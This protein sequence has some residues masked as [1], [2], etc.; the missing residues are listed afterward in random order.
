MEKKVFIS[1]SKKDKPVADLICRTLENENI[2]CWIAPRDIPYGNDW[3]GEIT[4]AIEQSSLFVFIL[5]EH[6]NASRQCPKEISIADNVGVPIIC[7]KTD[8]V[9]M[10]PGFKYHLSMQQMV[11]V[12]AAKINEEMTAIASAVKVKLNLGETIEIKSPTSAPK[13]NGEKYNIDKQLDEKFEEL[14]GHDRVETEAESTEASMSVK[15]KLADIAVKNFM[16]HFEDEA[17]KI[18]Q[19]KDRTE[20]ATI[21]LRKRVLNPLDSMGRYLNGKHFSIPNTD[22]I[23]TLVFQIKED[24]VDYESRSKYYDC[25]LLESIRE[26]ALGCTTYFVDDLSVEGASLIFIHFFE[27]GDKLYL[28]TGVLYNDVV[29]ICKKPSIM[30]FQKLCVSSNNI[31]LSNVGYNAES[32]SISDFTGMQGSGET[33]WHDADIRTAPIVVIDPETAELV[34]R[35]VYYDAASNSMKARMKLTNNKS[36]FAFQIRNCDTDSPYVSLTDLEQGI[37]YRKGL[38]GFPK[39]FMKAVEFLEKDGTS[40]ALYQMAL[41]FGEAGEYNDEG[42]YKQLL[43]ESADLNCENAIIEQTLAVAFH[44]IKEFDLK[45]CISRLSEIVTDESNVGNYVLAYLLEKVDFEKAFGLYLKSARNDYPPAISR[46]Q[47]SDSLLN[48]Q[49]VSELRDAFVKSLERE[50]GI[51]EYCMGCA[52][53]F[54]YGMKHR[55][56][57]GLKLILRS[58]E[59]GDIDAQKTMSDIYDSDEMYMDKAQALYWLEKVAAFDESVRVDLANRYIDGIGCEC[60]VENDSRAFE[61]LSTLQASDNRTAINNLAWMYKVG[62]GC[63]Q[64]YLKAKCLFER[65]ADMDCAASYYHLGTMYE[66][67]LGV[68][69]DIEQAMNLYKLA[70]DRGSKKAQ[71]RLGS[72]N[73]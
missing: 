36:Y 58:A 50:D 26:D 66:D 39:D 9:E 73:A 37:Y 19:R 2:G 59:L 54:G 12:D 41:L 3:A 34:L 18:E 1:H 25:A 56:E 40:E 70:A 20:T 63:E 45:V 71:E 47:G 65:S 23:K 7:V 61:W 27:S 15:A 57:Q 46:L 28:N 8:D 51:S 52:C 24:V 32:F 5:S 35:E 68:D 14:F 4:R 30:T 22:G 62:R 31:T 29:K 60:S 53:F 69:K 72:V 33:V 13:E 48:K 55:K 6:S 16:N 42:M 38:Y 21:E 17:K 10:N 49:E 44:E 11:I 64:D 67:G 43:K